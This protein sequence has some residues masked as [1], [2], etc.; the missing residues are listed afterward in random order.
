MHFAEPK[1][2]D[3]PYISAVE[4][5]W[6]DAHTIYNCQQAITPSTLFHSTQTHI[7]SH[8][9]FLSFWNCLSKCQEKMCVLL[10]VCGQSFAGTHVVLVQGPHVDR[11][12]ADPADKP[13]AAR[14]LR[15]RQ[16]GSPPQ[17]WQSPCGNYCPLSYARWI[18]SWDTPPPCHDLLQR[19]SYFP[20]GFPH[21]A[22]SHHCRDGW[23]EKFGTISIP[24]LAICVQLCWAITANLVTSL[25]TEHTHRCM[26]ARTHMCAY[27]HIHTHKQIR[28][29]L[30]KSWLKGTQVCSQT[31]SFKP[32]TWKSPGL[33]CTL[34]VLL[35]TQFGMEAQESKSITQEV[36]KTK[37]SPFP[38]YTP[39]TI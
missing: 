8:R 16:C 32:T 36:K 24:V 20:H 18:W 12:T 33:I 29:K 26:H 2:Q 10:Q 17:G 7:R 21:Q 22:W 39:Q 15:S 28:R 27:T 1:V 25:L 35:R 3:R 30:N 11:V 31:S 4:I 5:A 19:C 9:N 23:S 34:M 14:G 13:C 6:S 38:A 37:L